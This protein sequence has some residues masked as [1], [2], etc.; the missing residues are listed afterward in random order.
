MTAINLNYVHSNSIGYG[1][2]GVQLAA[3]LERAGV[4]VYDHL[5]SP[6]SP[7]AETSK[8]GRVSGV[9]SQTCWVSVPTHAKGWWSNQTPS[10]FTM[11]EATVLPESFR[12]SLH[13]FETIIVPSQQ[14]A[15]L[16]GRY[17]DNIR[18]VPLGVDPERWHYVPRTPPGVFFDFLIGGSGERKG[19]D[20]AY[21]AFVKVFGGYKA[22]DGPQPRLILKSPRGDQGYPHHPYITVVGGKLPDE[23]E[24]SLY[25][26]AHCYLQ[27]SRGEGFGLQPLQA[28]AQGMPTILTDAHGHESFAHLG[29]GISAELAQS[30]YFIYGDAGE[31]WEPS[32]DELC[33]RMEW[34][35]HNYDQA[36]A[37][38]AESATTVAEEFTWDRVGENFLAA[39]GDHPLGD[40]S[41]RGS[42]HAPELRRFPIIT[43]RDFSADIAGITYHFK[44]G[45][46]YWELA[47][48]KRILFE[49]GILDPKCLRTANV[50]GDLAP[51]TFELGLVESQVAQLDKYRA[52]REFCPHCGVR[53]GTGVTKADELWAVQ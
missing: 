25:A 46:E 45:E 41:D 16:F 14:N 21:R 49:A 22:G 35:F 52:D 39:L 47:D 6:E 28:I 37:N 1:R 2:L 40:L 9:A 27:P 19:T 48:V 13:E 42:W 8:E 43:N 53:A 4:T 20:L 15:E 51:D 5:P 17:H 29:L 7:S 33:E 10:V 38:A 50:D 36:C 34:V 26:S 32:F 31:W 23:D 12:E 3:S 44:K 30:G 11:W 24:V 18:Y